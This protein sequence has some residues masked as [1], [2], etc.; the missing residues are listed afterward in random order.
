MILPRDNAPSGAVVDGINIVAEDNLAGVIRLLNQD[1]VGP[2]YVG[3]AAG[4]R[5]GTGEIR[6]FADVKGQA[7]AKRALEVASAGGHNVL[8]VGPPGS[9]KSMLSRRLPRE[10]AIETTKVHSVSGADLREGL[11]WERPFRSPHHSISDAALIGG[12]SVP[13]PGEVSL[14]H[15]GVLFLD[16]LPEFHRGVIEVMRQPLESRRVTVARAKDT[17]TFPA[18]FMLV[19]AMNPCPCGFRGHPL[20][21]CLCSPVQVA[22]YMGRISGPLLDRIDIQIEVPALKMDEISADEGNAEKSEGILARVAMARERQL[23]RSAKTN[24]E[25]NTADIRRHCC[26]DEGGKSLLRAAM[27]RLNLSARAFHRILKVARTISDLE[28]SESIQVTHVAEAIQY[29][30]LDRQII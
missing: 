6:D 1:S 23:V 9:G 30:S 10:E 11:I 16:E 7:F 26:L 18:K 2:L 14:A 24:A 22:K 19:A 28:S 8:M 15:N 27:T 13:R 12:G 5:A 29:R 20:K 21:E 3:T 17:L 25:M 4:P